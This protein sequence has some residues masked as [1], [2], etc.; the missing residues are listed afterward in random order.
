MML[1]GAIKLFDNDDYIIY[2]MNSVSTGQYGV[3]VPKNING[4]LNMLI[5]LHFKNSFDSVNMG[6]KTTDLLINEIGEEYKKL[7]TRYADGML[8]IPMIDETSFQNVIMTGDKQKMFDEVKKISAITSE[9]YKKLTDSGVSKQK[10]DQKII[11]VEKNEV[12]EKFVIWLKEQMPNFVEGILYGELDRKEE[13]N[14]DIPS[15]NGLFGSPV[16]D[17]SIPVENVSNI[18]QNNSIFDS[19]PVAPVV[20]DTPT[21]PVQEVGPVVPV[22]TV[23]PINPLA[24]DDSGAV[25]ASVQTPEVNNGNNNDIFGAPVDNTTLVSP[26][27]TPAPVIS[28]EP[29]VPNLGPVDGPKPVESTNLEGTMI[30]NPV[31]ANNDV[32]NNN[33]D[34]SQ[35]NEEELN[36]NNSNKGFV[37][38]IILVV[39]LVGV[40]IVS[41]ELGKFLYNV[42]GA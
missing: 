36:P 21:V 35:N 32:V 30:I 2:T 5:D 39:I 6:N 23:A 33:V 16:G 37:N 28:N 15:G 25:V 4:V 3:V 12:D 31:P 22:A 20:P 7:K 10:I 9:L 11:V 41:I 19:A 18:S 24:T 42:Y 17:V 26:A 13:V 14:S 40:T 27:P 38:L 1:E 34:V 29:V 8:V